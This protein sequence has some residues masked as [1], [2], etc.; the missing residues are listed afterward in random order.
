MN[1][2]E[3][4][5][6]LGLAAARPL[7]AHA[8]RPATPVIGL[9]ASDHRPP[10]VAA[11]RQGLSEAGFVEGRNVAVEY[12]F[13]DGRYDRLPALAAD[14]VQRQVAVVAA[15]STPCALAAQAATRTTPIVFMVGVDPVALGL[16]S[17]LARPGG[18]ITGVSQ[19]I[20]EVV[21]KRMELLRKA[22][23]GATTI[24]MITNPANAAPSAGER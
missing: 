21:A 13:A 22:V 14:L 20:N 12:R 16:V 4:I 1:R 17:S 5:A 18:N 2:R 8:Q 6:G 23:P 11:F 9:L 3:V 19:L 24:A 15:I 10:F 7:T